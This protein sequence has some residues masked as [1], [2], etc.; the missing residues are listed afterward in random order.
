MER[1]GPLFFGNVPKK[2]KKQ[3]RLICLK[4]KIVKANTVTRRAGCRHLQFLH[5]PPL[6]ILNGLQEQQNSNL[7]YDKE[8]QQKKW[9]KNVW[10]TV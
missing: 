10:W 9:E 4:I 2:K 1:L 5:L 8:V 6:S 3:P 7:S